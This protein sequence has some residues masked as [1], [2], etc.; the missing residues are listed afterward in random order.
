MT[1]A[2]SMTVS[3]LGYREDD[4]RCALALEMDLRGYG[5]TFR[6]TLDDLRETMTM[7]IGFAH[8]NNELDMI[9]H[10]AEPVSCSLFAQVRNDHLTVL[11]R[12]GSV[13]ESEYAVAGIPIPP[14]HLIAAEKSGFSLSDA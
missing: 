4:D 8:F 11:A 7:Q 9:L 5:P 2:S 1:E 14:P 3:V 12:K 6:Q 13:T 10:P